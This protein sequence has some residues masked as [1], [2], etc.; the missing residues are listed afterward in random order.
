L[1]QLDGKPSFLL[2]EKEYRPIK[3]KARAHIESGLHSLSVDQQIE[4]KEQLGLTRMKF[5]DLKHWVNE[6]SKDDAE[7]RV[8]LDGEEL[9]YTVEDLSVNSDGDVFLEVFED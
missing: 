7:F 1:S 5:S 6:N 3:N 8:I 9:D 2:S 4:I